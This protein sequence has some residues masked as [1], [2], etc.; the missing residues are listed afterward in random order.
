MSIDSIMTE[1]WSVVW[2]INSAQKCSATVRGVSR[3]KEED[4]VHWQMYK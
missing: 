3:G 2:L 4:A 1:C